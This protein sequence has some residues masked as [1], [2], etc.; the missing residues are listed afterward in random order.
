MAQAQIV[1][2]DLIDSQS[3][4]DYLLESGQIDR[5][6]YRLL[7]EYF[8]IYAGPRTVLSRAITDEIEEQITADSLAESVEEPKPDRWH[9]AV[10]YRHY[11][12]I[13][14]DYSYRQMFTLRGDYNSDLQYYMVTEKRG[15]DGDYYFRERWIK[16][17]RDIYSVELG[18]YYPEWGMG[19]TTGYHSDFLDKSDNP[20]YQSALYPY[21]SR[22][23]GLRCEYESSLHPLVLLSY[24]RSKYYRG[25]LLAVGMNYNLADLQVGLLGNYHNLDNLNSGREFS[26]LVVG[27]YLYWNNSD[28]KIESEI[29]GAKFQDFAGILSLS[30]KQKWGQILFQGWNYPL[31]YINPYGGGRANSDYRTIS[32]DSTGI[33]YHSRQNGEYG[34]L[35]RTDY[36]FNSRHTASVT[37]N[38][39]R[40]GGQEKKYRLLLADN[41]K[42]TENIAG[43]FTVLFGDDNLNDDFGYRNHVRLDLTYTQRGVSNLRLSAEFKRVYYS[44]GRR[45]YLRTEIRYGRKFSDYSSASVKISRLDSD[46]LDGQPGYWLVYLEEDIRFADRVRVRVLLDSRE[47][48][49]YNLINSARINLQI[50]VVAD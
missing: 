41:I 23:N 6:Q 31:G 45:D 5:E 4:L 13:A 21:L 44:Y 50:T 28:Y 35:S 47:G 27:G 20:E 33:E 7:D 15:T 49:R 12:K 37:G 2:T 26:Q 43:R 22:Y 38:Y 11:Q 19:L 32:L 30:K 17:R 34:I 46:L 48:K 9:S 16:F 24:D 39:W 14:D 1:N 10:S 3:E 42:L 40:D 8:S 29:S 25:R 36:K 18:N